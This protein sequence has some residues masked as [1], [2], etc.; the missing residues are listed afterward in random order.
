VARTRIAESLDE[1]ALASVLAAS[2]KFT[3]SRLASR[4]DHELPS[5]IWSSLGRGA[6]PMRLV[7]EMRERL[8]ASDVR[9][10]HV[11][12]RDYPAQLAVDRERP[13][14]IYVR[15]RLEHL[16]RRRVAIVGT[17][18]ASASGRYFAAH[19]G[20]ELSSRGISVVSGLAR[21]IDVWAHRGVRGAVER[22]KVEPLAIGVVG[23]GLNVIYPPEHDEMWS[24]IGKEGLL[25]SE[26]APGVTPQKSYFPMR[27]RI[28]A[29]LAEVVVVVESRAAGG[30]MITVAEAMKRDVSVLAVP[31]SPHVGTS[32]GTNQLIA[33]GCVP[34]TDVDDVLVALG[35]DTRR[36]GA[37]TFD[38]RRALDPFEEHVVAAI[39]REA[40]TVDQIVMRS[41]SNLA[42]V[43]VTLGRLERDGWVLHAD[44]WWEVLRLP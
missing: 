32:R 20:F 25:I 2:G 33:Q 3:A 30:S 17:R 28:I 37:R 38:S 29:A 23:S 44:G 35:L 1:P 43:A 34:V 5:E 4:L 10:L 15:G 21:G 19:L 6:P 42:E 18:S 22:N 7:R 36:A 39:G 9:A 27:N 8:C 26:H 13:P 12:A 16:E 11:G 14:V 24:W 40:L 31:G 41:G